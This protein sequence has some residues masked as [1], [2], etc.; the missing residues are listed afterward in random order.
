MAVVIRILAGVG[1][2]LALLAQSVQASEYF[3]GRTIIG[4]GVFAYDGKSILLVD[5]SGDKSAMP[6]CASTGRFAI[7]SSSPGFKETVA[8]VMTA[9]AKG[10][11][12]VDLIAHSSCNSWSNAQDF[13]GIKMGTMPW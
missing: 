4:A 13:F 11:T 12:N 3:R 5:I 2:L 10:D 6:A 7:D 8:A 1:L 9:Y